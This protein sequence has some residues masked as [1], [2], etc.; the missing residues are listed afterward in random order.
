M[1]EDGLEPG[2]VVVPGGKVMERCVVCRQ[3]GSSLSA[4][5]RK[6]STSRSSPGPT[7]PFSQ[8]AWPRSKSRTARRSFD[9]F[10]DVL[11]A[12]ASWFDRSSDVLSCS[13]HPVRLAQQP[14]DL[15][16]RAGLLGGVNHRDHGHSHQSRRRRR[17]CAPANHGFRLHHRQPRSAAETR[18]PGSD[19][20]R[21]TCSGPLA[22]GRRRRHTAGPARGPSPCG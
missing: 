4:A 15:R 20:R 10:S 21:G 13:G 5:D 3:P 9:S 6:L 11:S 7:S 18:A 8:A 16:L 19:G 1:R 14:V 22:Q 2:K 12:P 17:A